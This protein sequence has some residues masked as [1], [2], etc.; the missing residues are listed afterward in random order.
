[1][2]GHPARDELRQMYRWARPRIA[3]PVHGERRHIL[4]HA[5][6]ALELQTPQ[7]VT[8]ANGDL[9]RLAP[10]EPE[11]I[12]EVPAGRLYVDGAV[13][14]DADDEALRDR[15]RM[16]AEG[17]V[18]VTMAVGAKKHSIVSGPEVRVRGLSAADEDDLETALEELAQ[19]AESAFNKLR[20]SER[21]DSEAAEEAVTKAVR[22]A[23]DR[24]W[25]KR[26][27]VEVVILEV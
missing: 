7:A 15:K 2:S 17:Q 11:T 1:V 12:D 18:I 9:I 22:R 23:A 10:G 5:R 26:P 21:A 24:A 16:A 3:V 27:L 25:G 19:A 6:L 8:P 13:T 14:I 20:A 4:E